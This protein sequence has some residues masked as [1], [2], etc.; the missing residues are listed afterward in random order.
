MP[1]LNKRLELFLSLY[2]SKL[3]KDNLDFGNLK[4]SFIIPTKYGS[5]H[6][7]YLS[8]VVRDNLYSK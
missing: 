5:L 1:I 7:L 8:L 6:I 3:S 2:L 4:N